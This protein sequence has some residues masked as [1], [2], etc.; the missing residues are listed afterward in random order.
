MADYPGEKERIE[1]DVKENTQ[2]CFEVFYL[3]SKKLCPMNLK[4]VK[5]TCDHH[6]PSLSA[7]PMES[8]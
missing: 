1:A 5:H 8:T 7:L 2:D 4:K 6:R 3:S